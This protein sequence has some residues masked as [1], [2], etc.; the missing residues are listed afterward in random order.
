LPLA[1]YPL[2]TSRLDV[3]ALLLAGAQG[4]F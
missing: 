3:V 2:F 1:G 4:F